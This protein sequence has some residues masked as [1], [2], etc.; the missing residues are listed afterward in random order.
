MSEHHSAKAFHW[1]YLPSPWAAGAR[2]LPAYTFLVLKRS[3]ISTEV[4]P[5]KTRLLCWLRVIF[6]SDNGP[7][8]RRNHH[9]QTIDFPEFPSFRSW[10]QGSD[11][12]SKILPSCLLEGD[13]YFFAIT[14]VSFI[15]GHMIVDRFRGA[16]YF[17]STSLGGV[18]LAV[19]R[20][21]ALGDSK[22]TFLFVTF[23]HCVQNVQR[24]HVGIEPPLEFV[25]G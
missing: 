21:L 15:C 24:K 2:Q 4:V 7:V 17:L 8:G 1:Q 22:Q 3:E 16:L 13:N 18:C 10:S 12:F 11:E 6:C 19:F 25:F 9:I 5:P 20:S 23:K 14:A